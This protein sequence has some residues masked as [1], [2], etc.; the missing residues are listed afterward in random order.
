[1]H[2][3]ASCIRSQPLLD[4]GDQLARTLWTPGPFEG[5]VDPIETISALRERAKPL[6]LDDEPLQPMGLGHLRHLR[7]DDSLSRPDPRRMFVATRVAKLDVW[8][9]GLRPLREKNRLTL[10]RPTEE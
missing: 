9:C 3:D 10:G 4:V 8:D 2:Y 1:M 5:I 7:D 6:N